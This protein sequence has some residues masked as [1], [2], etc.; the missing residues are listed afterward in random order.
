MQLADRA[1]E[2]PG[3]VVAAVLASEPCDAGLVFECADPPQSETL[4]AFKLAAEHRLEHLRTAGASESPGIALVGDDVASTS[5]QSPFAAA[6]GWRVSGDWVHLEAAGD[7]RVLARTGRQ[8]VVSSLQTALSMLSAERI[9]G[10][11]PWQRRIRD[12]SLGNHVGLEP[13]HP[14]SSCSLRREEVREILVQL[15]SERWRPPDQPG[16]SVG[17]GFLAYPLDALD[18]PGG[19]VVYEAK[20]KG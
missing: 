2:W 3:H 6:V 7:V 8:W 19:R 12:L 5:V 20:A 10:L 1:L 9:L 14:P 18:H 16:A 15:G 17:L 11:K 4:L 13:P